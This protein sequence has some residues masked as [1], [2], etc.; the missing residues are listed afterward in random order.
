MNSRLPNVC[1]YIKAPLRKLSLTED[2]T[3]TPSLNAFRP[4][5][6]NKLPINPL[7]GTFCS[8]QSKFTYRL[9]PNSN[10]QHNH[11]PSLSEERALQKELQD[12]L[13]N[14]EAHNQG[15]REGQLYEAI[16]KASP[17]GLEEEKNTLISTLREG[18]MFFE[19][20]RQ[21]L[22]PRIDEIKI[23]LHPIKRC[24]NEILRQ[25]FSLTIFSSAWA[26]RVHKSLP[27]SHVCQRWCYV[28]IESPEFWSSFEVMFPYSEHQL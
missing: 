21:N 25:I 18:I 2:N 26:Y 28:M 6:W 24:P 27:V 12:I 17:T 9:S 23:R 1:L 5:I 16:V 14:Q 4:S 7:Q 10:Q 8:K 20:L 15:I 13:A 22:Q 11:P 19:T 3:S